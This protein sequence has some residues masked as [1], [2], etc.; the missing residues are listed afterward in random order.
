MITHKIKFR[1]IFLPA[2][3]LYAFF[4][5]SCDK[6][7]APYAVVKKPGGDTT[8][9]QRKVLL[10]DYTGHKC[11]NCPE[12][13]EAAHVLE[14]S[15][16]GKLIVMAVHAGYLAEPSSSGDFTADYTTAAGDEWFS[17]FGFIG[18][19]LGLVNRTAYKGKVVLGP[20][21]WANA[22]DTLV[23]LPP[24]AG[25][26][27]TNTY[28]PDEHEVI[29]T[30]NTKFKEKLS[31]KYSITVCILEDSLI[32][33]QKNNNPEVG[34]TPTIFDYVFMDVLRIS[35]NGT[36]GEELTAVVDTAL[37]YK[38]E[39]TFTLDPTWVPKN[40]S[41]VGFVSN[42]ETREIIQAEKVGITTK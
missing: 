15:Y 17:Y 25:I 29:I 23:N 38:K 12:A 37:T 30:T 31:G 19:P 21:L 36:W 3:L 24:Q 1:Y 7:E 27:I 14:N 32:S 42:E 4:I 16:G 26:K 39:Y 10:E 2:F 41:I 13:S 18:N 28:D 20:D 8:M 34:P 11:V 5:Q 40:C 22:I 9:V 33:P 6:L 35:V